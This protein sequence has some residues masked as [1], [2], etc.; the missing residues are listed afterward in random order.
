[1]I[2]ETSIFIYN[3][4][5]RKREKMLKEFKTFLSQGNVM[6]LAVGMIIGAAFG[7]IVASLVNDV[8]MPVIAYLMGGKSAAALSFVLKQGATPEETVAINYGLFIQTII[9][10]VIIAFVIFML[11]KA[12]NKVRKPKVEEAPAG[13][14]EDVLLLR[15]IRDSLKK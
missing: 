7:K 11:I 2:E 13:P 14:S 4:I 3:S 15:E 8:I 12:V 10:F 6:D 1:M 5:E 9:D